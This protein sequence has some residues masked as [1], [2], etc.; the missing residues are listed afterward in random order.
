MKGICLTEE[1]QKDLNFDVLRE[2]ADKYSKDEL[3]N[4]QVP[5]LQFRADQH[6]NVFTTI[7]NKNY[8]VVSE[9]RRKIGNNTVP[10]GF[11]D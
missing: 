11:V 9:K 10:Y 4:K 7:F 1:V 2:F 8:R 3:L 6:H 5:Q